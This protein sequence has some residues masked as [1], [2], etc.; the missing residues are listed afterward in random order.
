MKTSRLKYMYTLHRYLPQHQNGFI[1]LYYIG[2][3]NIMKYRI[4]QNVY[5]IINQCTINDYN[6][7]RAIRIYL[8]IYNKYIL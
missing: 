8:I 6:N 7:V 5:L 1:I 4:M 3:L 2:N